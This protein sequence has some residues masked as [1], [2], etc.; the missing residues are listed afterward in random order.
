MRLLPVLLV[1]LSVSSLGLM[2]PN[3]S[4]SSNLVAQ[5]GG[6]GGLGDVEDATTDVLKRLGYD[7][8]TA[9][10]GIACTKCSDNKCKA[11]I[12]DAITKKCRKQKASLPG[13]PDS[14]DD[15][16]DVIDIPGSD[17]LTD[18]V[19]VPDSGDLIDDVD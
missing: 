14:V 8:K 17:D 18:D 9:T 3:P 13:V 6:L 12:C 5:L 7:C 19:D 15:L 2:N 10:V 11:Y 16:T 4:L 1:S